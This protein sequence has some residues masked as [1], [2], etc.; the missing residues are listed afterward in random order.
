MPEDCPVSGFREGQSSV[1]TRQLL[2]KRSLWADVQPPQ[3]FY[4][5]THC[6]FDQATSAVWRFRP[7]LERE[8]LA[9]LLVSSE[10]ALPPP[11]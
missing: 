6:P 2:W 9:F 8:G 3:F 4:T 5:M 1:A 10:I 7:D 11:R